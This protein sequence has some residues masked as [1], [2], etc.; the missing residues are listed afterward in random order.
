MKAKSSTAQ[1]QRAGN[2]K[3]SRDK[4]THKTAVN[5]A[6][7]SRG[8]HQNTQANVDGNKSAANQERSQQKPRMKSPHNKQQAAKQPKPSGKKQ[9]AGKKQAGKKSADKDKKGAKS[10]KA[11]AVSQQEDDVAEDNPGNGKGK[12]RGH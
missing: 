9:Q 7:Q 8:A 1:Q 4:V 2:T 5:A 3:Q 11:L 12:G 6:M 10:E